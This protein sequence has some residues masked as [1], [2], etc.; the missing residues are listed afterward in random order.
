[1][2]RVLSIVD[3]AV[4]GLI[5]FLMALLVVVISADVAARY[6]FGG[7]LVYSNELSR[8]TFIWICFLGMP[9]CI[10]KGLN[11]AITALESRLSRELQKITYRLGV[12]MVIVLLGVVAYGAW[13]SIGERS[14][15]RLN[16][17]PLSAAWFFFPVLIGSLHS[18]LH[19][20][21]E[22]IRGERAVRLAV[23]IL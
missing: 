15:E 17:I 19:L 11:V 18:I 4:Q 1:M 7:S 14:A 5:I 22:F 9:L 6:F 21:Q 8:M 13:I 20:I 2:S 23:D 3:L 16:T 10:V 12:V